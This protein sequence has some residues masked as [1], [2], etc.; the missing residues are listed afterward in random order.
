MQQLRL[1]LCRAV[2]ELYVLHI[3]SKGAGTGIWAPKTGQL[4]IM[5]ILSLT[6]LAAPLSKVRLQRSK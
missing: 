3:H 6:T 2:F 1:G 5:I 4:L